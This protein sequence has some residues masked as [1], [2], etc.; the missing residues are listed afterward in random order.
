MSIKGC[1]FAIIV[2]A[3]LNTMAQPNYP[4]PKI[5]MENF[6]YDDK[7]SPNTYRQTD[8]PFYWKNRI[9]VPG[10]WQQDVHYTLDANIDEVNDIIN[11]TETL[12]YWNNSPDTLKIVYFHLYQNAFQPGSY[13][14]ELSKENNFL[15]V[16]GKKYEAKQLGTVVENLKVNGI[17]VKTILDN[18]I[19]QV[20]LPRP[21]AP[22]QA[23][24]FEMEFKTYFDTGNQ[25]RRMKKFDVEGHKDQA[26]YR[27]YD[28][29][30]WYPRICVYDAKMG[31]DTQQ[32]LGK[33][34][35]GD[36][37]A[38][39]LSLTFSANYVVEATGW[40]QNEEEV[41]PK[42]LR[43]KLDIKNF[44]SKKNKKD[45]LP[46]LPYSTTNRK[47]WKYHAE[48][49]H[50]V[51]WTADPSYRIGESTWQGI[52]VIALVQEAHAAGW[53]N[54]ADYTA[55]VI[56]Y[57]SKTVGR[58]AYPK[59]VV[60][61]AQDG[62]EYPMLTLDGG[63]DPGYRDLLAHEV[64]HN[65]FFGMVGNNETYRA[66]LDEGFTQFLNTNACKALDGPYRLTGKNKSYA[67]KH[68]EPDLIMNSETYNGYM[69]DAIRLDKT[70]L[71]TASDDF[72]AALGHGG[73]YRNVY[74][75][76]ST[77]L[78]NLQYVL[79]DSL[80]WHAMHHYFDQWKIAHPYPEDFRS[81]IIRFTK[82][83]LNWFFDQWMETSKTIDYAVQAIRPLKNNKYNITLERKGD[84]QMPIDLTI[85]DNE[86]NKS[87]FHIPNN[88]FQKQTTATVLPK[89]YGWG[90]LNPKYSFTVTVPDGIE[91]VIIDTTNRLAD[92]NPSNNSDLGNPKLR[93][94]YLVN[95]P[96]NRS[97][98]QMY[99][100]PDMWWNGMDG[101]KI[102]AIF[103]GHYMNTKNI[104]NA[105][106]WINTH[107]ATSIKWYDY[108]IK[109]Y[110]YAKG[111]TVNNGILFNNKSVYDLNAASNQRAQFPIMNFINYQID[112]STATDKFIKNSSIQLNSQLMEGFDRQKIQFNYNYNGNNSFFL[113]AKRTLLKDRNYLADPASWGFQ[114]Y[115]NNPPVYYLYSY[116]PYTYYDENFSPYLVEHVNLKTSLGWEH[117]Y[118]YKNGNG[119]IK[120]QTALGLTDN[121][122]TYSN[123][124]PYATAEVT[125]LNTHRIDK[126]NIK[127][128]L[129]F[130]FSGG[131]L[132]NESAV[133]LNGANP[134][135]LLNTAVTRSVGWNQPMDVFN[136][137][138]N[139]PRNY[140]VGG[141]LN[142][143]NFTNDYYLNNY[144]SYYK[145]GRTGIAGNMEVNFSDYF[146]YHPKLTR[147]WLRTNIYTYL[148]LGLLQY[149]S[150]LNNNWS[151]SGSQY[152]SKLYSDAGLGFAF[153]IFKW[154]P[155]ETL[156]PITFR[157]DL[158]FYV[159]NQ[160]FYAVKKVLP[161]QNNYFNYIAF[162]INRAF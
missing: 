81:S 111:V 66:M 32:H 138:S 37:G 126:L 57:Y 146:T 112:Y 113:Q 124:R 145:R 133:Y 122:F 130:N 13:L 44:V 119:I 4:S 54:A 36:Y 97:N 56:E 14:D 78:F 120:T 162:G 106:F 156:K 25:R 139:Q 134:E 152:W 35:Y 118:A 61:D 41:L 2:C 17:I 33:E 117:R 90:K 50:D 27:H 157:I 123:V 58:Y 60:A 95:Q 16:W 87:S 75:K 100:R 149:E 69:S 125:V 101:F 12:E 64:G 114:N 105:G 83:D 63:S 77:M 20:T 115:L 19:L 155:F 89:W 9:P 72:N 30:H 140:H 161:Y 39:D 136:N 94:D 107:R 96:V 150:D 143:R 86:G 102:G 45:T 132:P 151:I 141:G 40:L 135:E 51:A 109:Y 53:Q 28:G 85:I 110:N 108:R 52:K 38:F 131:N 18:T 65:W 73:G 137:Y 62:M 76:T 92:T 47:T 79:G 67:A 29:V 42:S 23:I 142:I 1:L 49:V 5:K 46:L 99:W 159:S 10:Y 84:M 147:K 121:E 11:G 68:R 26:G 127:T 8:N 158:P 70:T 82:V 7:H 88:W 15:S 160:D 48:N 24:Q 144:F 148:D 21:L 55:K 59:M 129:Y 104:I 98:Y 22:N 93:F 43:E 128:R 116:I 74:F 31:W 3:N 80:F 103:K 154:G 6:G 91:N 153:T 34:F 71:N